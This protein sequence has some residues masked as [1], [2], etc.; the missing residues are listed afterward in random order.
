MYSRTLGCVCHIA[1]LHCLNG[2]LHGKHAHAD[3]TFLL[4]YR[5]D[6]ERL[7]LSIELYHLDLGYLY[8]DMR[9]LDSSVRRVD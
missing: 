7:L 3:S 5:G 9:S 4:K 8:R 6:R 1:D 2:T